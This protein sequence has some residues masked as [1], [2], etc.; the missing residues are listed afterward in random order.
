MSPAE[1][2][3]PI[4]PTMRWRVRARC[5]CVGP[6]G[7]AGGRRLEE[8]FVLV[9]GLVGHEQ[10][11]A[12]PSLDRPLH[13]LERCSA[14]V[15]VARPRSHT[16]PVRFWRTAAVVI[17]A[18]AGATLGGVGATAGIAGAEPPPT[19]VVF[20]QPGVYQWTVPPGVQSATFDLHGAAG[21]GQG[22]GGAHVTA[23]LP[24]RPRAVLTIVVGGKG[25]D[26][27]GPAAGAGGFGGGAPGGAGSQS[28]SI[29]GVVVLPGGPGGGGGGGASDVRTGS[30]GSGQPGDLGD[31]ESRLLVAG[32]GGGSGAVG[33]GTSG[34]DGQPGA[35]GQ[36]VSNFPEIFPP[37]PVPGGDGGTA[38]V[39][40][41][42][43]G[44]AASGSAGTGGAGQDAPP[45]R[46]DF[47]SGLVILTFGGQGGG[48]GGSGYFG[49]GGGA[50]AA[51]TAGTTILEFFGTS[52]GGGGGSSLVPA[53]V[54]CPPTIETGVSPSDGSVVI[55]FRHGATPHHLCPTP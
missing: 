12:A 27:S 11:G 42:G 40:G 45:T 23:T 30:G 41:A 4:E 19:R 38:S 7:V 14:R 5:P 29:D 15:D 39:G 13:D 31:L 54:L 28:L 17:G 10:A 44:G 34:A 3:W 36:V 47:F 53:N 26:P 55:T 35:D 9:V 37:Q 46:V 32:G 20:D 43:G 8:P 16:R 49:G 50:S 48:G 2:T 1:P 21:G 52:A 18:F 24:V 22:G 6:A 51:N 33:G 25:A